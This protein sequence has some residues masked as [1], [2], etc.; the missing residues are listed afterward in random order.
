LNN[1][2]HIGVIKALQDSGIPIHLVAGC[3]VGAFVGAV[4]AIG[5]LEH[6]K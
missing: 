1:I 5:G 3:S 6:V 2:F 4:F